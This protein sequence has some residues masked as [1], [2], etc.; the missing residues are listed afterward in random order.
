MPR[1]RLIVVTRTE[2]MEGFPAILW[3]V[4]WHA[5]FSYQPKYFVYVHPLG[6]DLDECVAKVVLH[7]RLV[8]LETEE[9]LKYQGMRSYPKAAIQDV[10]YQA[11]AGLRTRCL[12]L[13]TSHT[14]AYFP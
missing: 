8:K 14:F 11:M 7:P 1:G 10:A 2:G 9:P 4:M 5:N 13:Q 3:E 6:P 12:E